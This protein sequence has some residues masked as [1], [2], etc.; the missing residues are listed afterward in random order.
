[1]ARLPLLLLFLVTSVFL[2]AAPWGWLFLS[3]VMRSQFNA[4]QAR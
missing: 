4:A 3:T 1:M 2:S